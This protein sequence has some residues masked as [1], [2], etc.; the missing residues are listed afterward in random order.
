VKNSSTLL[1]HQSKVMVGL[2]NWG[3][4]KG[5]GNNLQQVLKGVGREVSGVI[6]VRCLGYQRT[7]R[8][9]HFFTD[10]RG[11]EM[12]TLNMSHRT[13]GAFN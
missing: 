6:G 8:F 10:W 12:G 1:L 4:K 13:G 2:G 7:D 9:T 5:R 11:S 3:E